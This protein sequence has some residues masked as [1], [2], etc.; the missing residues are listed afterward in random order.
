MGTIMLSYIAGRGWYS[1]SANGDVETEELAPDLHVPRGSLLLLDGLP[2]EDWSQGNVTYE[3]AGSRLPKVIE[4]YSF[5][6]GAVRLSNFRQ[7][8]IDY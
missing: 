7:E 6:F 5:R 1:A 4:D 2:T 3:Q 8:D